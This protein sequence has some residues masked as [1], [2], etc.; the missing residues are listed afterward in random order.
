MARGSLGDSSG[1]DGRPLLSALMKEVDN[2]KL[3]SCIAYDN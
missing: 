1:G 2:F 3:K